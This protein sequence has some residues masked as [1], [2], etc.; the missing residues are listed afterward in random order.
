M[1]PNQNSD[2]NPTTPQPA[3]AP[4]Q[5]QAIRYIAVDE[6]GTPLAQQPANFQPAV[7]A[8]AAPQ[9]ETQTSAGPEQPQ[10]VYMSRP[11]DPQNPMI[12]DETKERHEASQKQYP[13]LNLSE[14]EYIVSAVTRHPIGLLSVWSVVVIMV[15][16]LIGG[17]AA[18]GAYVS[19][20]STN[21]LPST[22]IISLPV[23]ILA[24][25]AVLG[26]YI[27]TIVYRGNK[28]FLTN[29]SVIQ[30]IQSSL[31]AKREQTVSLENIEDASF[32]QNGIIQSMIGYGSIRLST[33]GD[34]TTYRFHYVNNPKQQIALLNNAVESFKNGRPVRA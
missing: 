17:L 10:V 19:N 21:S 16:I 14:G 2:P 12:S 22:A 27:S 3:P 5:P 24:V 25:M 4:D 8:I 26:G 18:Y 32:T 30:E 28:F 20:N 15:L 1:D 34:E 6:H 7:A 13:F 9:A 31:F 11:L 23:I 29:E 33:Q